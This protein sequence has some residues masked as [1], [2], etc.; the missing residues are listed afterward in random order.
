MAGLE[1]RPSRPTAMGAPT[2]KVAAIA[3][4]T[5]VM[6][7]AVSFS[8]TTSR[9]PFVPNRRMSSAL[10][11]SSFL[12]VYE[13]KVIDGARLGPTCSPPDG[14]RTRC[15][16]VWPDTSGSSARTR[17]GYATWTMTRSYGGPPPRNG[18]C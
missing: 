4:A 5:R 14:W 6:K 2:G 15:W 1:V 9:M 12:P 10:G 3:P 16:V 18:S 13:R 17:P 8:P 11:A 7:A